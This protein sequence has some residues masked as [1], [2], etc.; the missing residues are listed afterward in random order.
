MHL[1]KNKTHLLCSQYNLVFQD[2]LEKSTNKTSSAVNSSS[3]R[4]S[5][6]ITYTS[7]TINTSDSSRAIT[8][9]SFFLN[10]VA[11]LTLRIESLSS[12]VDDIGTD[13]TIM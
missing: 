12:D 13:S 6:T 4:A 7:F 1:D 9:S 11:W 10:C 2:M 3:S 5:V 8:N